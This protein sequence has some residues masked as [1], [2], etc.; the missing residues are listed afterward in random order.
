MASDSQHWFNIFVN[1]D[2]GNGLKPIWW[3]A[4]AD[5]CSIIVDKTSGIKHQKF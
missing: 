2:I 3:Q 5:Q 1:N 4:N